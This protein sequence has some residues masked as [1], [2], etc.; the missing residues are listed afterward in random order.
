MK[1]DKLTWVGRILSVLI[2]LPFVMSVYMKFFPN[3]EY[4]K[5]MAH[6]GLPGSITVTIAAL[7]AMCVVFYLIPQT[8]VLGA[9]LFT[10]Y[11]GGAILTHLRVG[12]PAYLQAL[13]GA[14]IWLGIYLRE[15]RLRQILPIRR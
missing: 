2:A 7:E 4:A 12:E 1:A 3:A 6:L 10:G 5:N 11:L 14:I 15:P 13:F 9:I 8:S